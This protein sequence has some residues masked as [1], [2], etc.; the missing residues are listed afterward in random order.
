MTAFYSALLRLYPVSFRLEY[1]HELTRT[2]E[3]SIRDR[4]R[5]GAALAAIADVVPNAI[6][7]HWA[8]LAQDLRYTARSLNGSRGFAVAT[9]LVTAL[10]VGANVA[11]FSVAD[12][13]LVRPLP[14]SDPDR[15]VRLCEG[16]REG[17]GWGCM[18][19][20]PPGVYRDVVTRSRAFSTLG[21]F[22]RLALNLAGS[23]EPAR[24]E[25]ARFSPEVFALLGVPA[26]LGRT[27]DTTAAGDR[28]AQ[29]AVIGHRLWQSQFGADDRIIGMTIRL[30]GQAYEVIGV[31]PPHFLF[32]VPE[33]QV[34]LPLI[35]RE[36][37]Y[38][39]RV[40]NY[41]EG[42]G[43]LGPGVSFERARDDLARVADEIAREF[44]EE[45]PDIGF[46]FS[47]QRDFMSPRYRLMLLALVGA[48]LCM[49]LLTC[50]NLANLALARAAGRERELAVRAAL[51]AGRERLVRQMLTE[52]MVL[53]LLGGIAGAAAA[54]IAVPLLTQLV[55]PSLPLA[56]SPSV[57]LRVLA[58]AAAF[59]AL[60]G[61]G[62]GLVP[63]LRAGQGSGFAVL[64][65]TRGSAGRQR[66]RRVLVA[67][68][69]AVSVVLIISSGLLIRAVWRVQSV[70]PGFRVGRVL[71][72]TTAL[73]S[74]QYDS[75]R[76]AQFYSQVLADVR[77]LPGVESAAYTSG[78]PMVMTGGIT[79][80]LLPG[81]VDRRDG[82]QSASIRLVT[83]GFF[84]TMGI[85]VRQGRDI[86]ETDVPDAPLV[87][88]VSTSLAHRHWPNEDPIGRTFETRGQVRSVVGVVGD[89]MVRGIERTSE[90]QLYTPALQPPPGIADFYLPKDLVVRLARPAETL[91]PAIRA[92]VRQVDPQQ[93]ISAVRMLDE[94]VGDQ[95]APRR[96]Q[97][98]ILG[99]LAGL[100]LLLA[101][102]GIHGLLSFTVSQRDREIGVR[103]ALGARP[104]GV[105]RMI[106]SEGV[107]M[108]V[109]GV[110][111]GVLIA[112]AA[113]R[114]M[115]S[116]LFGIPPQDPFTIGVG[117]GLCFLVAA[118][119]CVRPAIRASRIDPMAALRAD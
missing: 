40:N 96:A 79:R 71:T 109:L 74:Q 19:Q 51:G 113:A 60:T 114:A 16:P 54:A 27:F 106:L 38:A 118:V 41:L 65:E 17:G 47:T 39:E 28:D 86:G 14:F 3:E 87:A 12:F 7:A 99:A 50:A 101:G 35:L 36:A 62:F 48:S 103:L 70:D 95:T 81:E 18:N 77:A 46:S 45:Q 80:I 94:V 83:S 34:W 23:G 73:A 29:S 5:A 93:P 9:I 25:A 58:I 89:I 21:A 37:D 76:R 8:I 97:V 6:A 78:L 52:S 33:V 104:A 98:R 55:P 112:W 1:E 115:S 61:L 42:V 56:S 10:G 117:A 88:V 32:P 72:L 13:V 57:D 111:P 11:T 59:A 63:A 44:P 100:A 90:P 82:T 102:I 67:V 49:L 105:A 68:E 20:M 107:R 84:S 66:L 75:L 92:I 64:R 85:P 43:R 110:I 26:M 116:M 31:M 108:A 91:L 4:G 22:Q 53:A 30:D 15:L 24:V 2:Y 69:V 119:G